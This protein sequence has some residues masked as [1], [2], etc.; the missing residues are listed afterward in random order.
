MSDLLILAAG[1]TRHLMPYLLSQYCAET[2]LKCQC[3]Y[4]RS[5]SFKSKIEMGAKFSLFISTSSAHTE[6][7]GLSGKLRRYETLGSNRLVLLH[8]KTQTIHRNNV[9]ILFSDP[10][11]SLGLST[12]G[13][14]PTIGASEIIEEVCR[15]A[16]IPADELKSRTRIITGGR[17][18]PNAPMNR[19]QYGWIMETQAVDLILTI[20]S[21]AIDAIDDNPKLKFSK[22]PLSVDMVMRYG[23][24]LAKD[25]TNKAE[26]LFDW[27]LNNNKARKI[28]IERGFS[29]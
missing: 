19:N 24:G 4:G 28:L 27:L 21:N 5:S 18:K 15:A 14:D 25:A 26:E 22:L 2:K 11:L 3:E 13:F 10:S 1:S 23:L 6:S 16:E 9:L 17:E 7:L 12:T 29:F 8:R 20:Q